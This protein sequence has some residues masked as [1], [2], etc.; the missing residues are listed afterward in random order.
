MKYP[1]YPTNKKEALKY[2][3][4]MNDI[5]CKKHIAIRREDPIKNKFAVNFAAVKE[6]ELSEYVGNGWKVIDK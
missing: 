5:H 2:A 4:W 1:K 3:E 6:S